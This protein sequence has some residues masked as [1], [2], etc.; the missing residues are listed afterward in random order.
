M[1]RSIAQSHVVFTSVADDSRL[2]AYMY[3]VVYIERVSMV[4]AT[5]LAC[6]KF[7]FCMQCIHMSLVN[8][9]MESAALLAYV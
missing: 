5:L 7:L 8:S 6:C 2:A 9:S 1:C 3:A 4:P